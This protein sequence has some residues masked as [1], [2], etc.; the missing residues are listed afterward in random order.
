MRHRI[1]DG[2]PQF[3]IRWAGFPASFETWEPRENVLDDRLL[4]GYF[5]K[6][7][8]AKCLLDPD[9]DYRPRVSA[10]SLNS[11]NLTGTIVAVILL[12]LLVPVV[13]RQKQTSS[14]SSLR[15]SH[16]ENHPAPNVEA[17]DPISQP[18]TRKP[19]RLY[20]CL[21]GIVPTSFC[22]SSCR[23]VPPETIRPTRP[24]LSVHARIPRPGQPARDECCGF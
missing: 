24:S 3:L 1:R 5:Q 9:P 7:P 16:N 15:V 20:K 17:R 23:S 11:G 4:Q 13:S 8:G 14:D 22:P 18:L 19:A 6:C 21:F 12:P 10:L 2:C